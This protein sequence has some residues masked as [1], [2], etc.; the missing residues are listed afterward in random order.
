MI[1]HMLPTKVKLLGH[2]I[3]I[4]K[5]PNMRG[6]N[7]FGSAQYKSGAINLSPDLPVSQ[8]KATIIHELCHFIL[9]YTGF[10]QWLG[11]EINQ[12]QKQQDLIEEQAVR[13]ME[14]GLTDL[15][16]TNP[17]LIKWILDENSK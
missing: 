8:E 10:L 5:D 9:S 13:A 12:N 1:V 3:S 2:T 14:I 11:M 15:I 6:T 7:L 16:R 4:S 17:K